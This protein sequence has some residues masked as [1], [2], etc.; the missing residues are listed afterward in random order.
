MQRKTMFGL[1]GKWKEKM[2]G[3]GNF[4]L[5]HQNS[6]SS[7]WGENTKEKKDYSLLFQKK[8]ALALLRTLFSAQMALLHWQPMP[9]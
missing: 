6:I 8:I 2:V 5:G 9:H 7:N 4:S 3:L 1:E